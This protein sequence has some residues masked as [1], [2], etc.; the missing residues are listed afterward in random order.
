MFELRRLLSRL[1]YPLGTACALMGVGLLAQLLRWRRFGLGLVLVGFGWLWLWSTP[2]FS[3]FVRGQLEG[4][5]AHS[6]VTSVP[7]AG[8]IVVLGGAF[9]HAGAWPYPNL[10]SAADRYWHG[11]RLF[12]AGKGELVMLSGGRSPGRGEGLTEAEAGEWFLVD[13]GVPREAIVLDTRALT[14]RDNA[15]NVAVMLAEHGIEDFLLVTS[16]LHMRRS[17]A[18]FRAVGLDPIPVATDFEVRPSQRQSLRRWL[19][20][21]AALSASARAAHEIVGYWVYRGRGW[22]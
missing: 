12:H 19:P 17:E 8:A 21:A 18:A 3:D 6:S 11:A 22:I 13:L 1:V 2:V 5:Y 4:R 15:V 7:E 20:S 10:S 16:A 9:M 14:T